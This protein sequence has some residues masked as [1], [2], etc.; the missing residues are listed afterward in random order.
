MFWT[1]TL[2]I[3][4][5]LFFVAHP[6]LKIKTFQKV[7]GIT[8]F[9]EM[10][11]LLGHYSLGWP[12]PTPIV[13]FQLFVVTGIGVVLGVFFS[14]IWPLPPFKGIERIFRTF[15]LVIPALGLGMG[16]QILLQGAQA[17]QAIYLIFALAA[18]LGSDHFVRK[19]N[20]AKAVVK[21]YKVNKA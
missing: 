14:R 20:S 11:Y 1:I 9:L 10:F 19:Q 5:M 8:L 6:W 18:W 17:T 21:D 12:F 15:L 2:G 7:V 13:L 3:S 4:M 16:L